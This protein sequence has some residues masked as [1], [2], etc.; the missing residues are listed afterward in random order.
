[1][2]TWRTSSWSSTAWS[3][4]KGSASGGR[5]ETGRT[6][7]VGAKSPLTVLSRG[8][9]D[10][11]SCS[12][13]RGRRFLGDVGVLPPPLPFHMSFHISVAIGCSRAGPSSLCDARLAQRLV[14]KKDIALRRR[15]RRRGR[16]KV[17]DGAGSMTT[18]QE[19]RRYCR[20]DRRKADDGASVDSTVFDRAVSCSP[21][22]LHGPGTDPVDSTVIDLAMLRR[23]RPCAVIDLAP[24]STLQCCAVIDASAQGP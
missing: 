8:R 18:Q 14:G 23:R 1:M 16:R 22:R 2:W 15:C 6:S 5:R 10:S 11:A 9:G 13:G 20:R 4:V 17:D 3:F 12:T 21:L 7:W 24:S 19:R